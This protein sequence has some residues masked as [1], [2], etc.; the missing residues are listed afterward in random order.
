MDTLRFELSSASFTSAVTASSLHSHSRYFFSSVQLG[1]VGSSSPAITSVS[2][3]TVNEICTADELHY[4]PVPNSDWRVALWR[5]LPSPKAPKRN[6]P[7]LLLSGIG[8]NAV[9][10]DLSPECSFAR[11]M[12]GSGFDTWILELRGA[13]LSSLS[14]DTNLGKGNN[15]Q[16][17]VSNLLENFISV[18]ERLENVLDGGSKILGMQDR[19]SK[20]AGDFKQRFELIP[21][22]NWDF[23]NYLEEDVPSAM[24][25]VRTQTKSKDGKLLAVGHSMGGILL[26][27]LLSR[28]GFKGMDSG[29]AGV[30]TLASTFDYS[31]SGTLLKYLLPMKEPA[32]AINLPIMPIDTM[33]AMAH[34][35]MCRPPYSLSWL[36]ANISAPQMMDPEVIE[37]LVLNS[38]CTVP[39]KLLLQLTTAVDHGGLRDR[40]GTFCYKDHISKTNVPILALAGDW[41]I[42]CPPDAVYDTV[43]LIPEHLATYKVVG[44]PGG[45]HYGHQDL[46]SGR[47]ARNEVYPL[48]TRFLQQQDES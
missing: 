9:T 8:T 46:I 17:I 7:L 28:C 12:S 39:V 11:S 18:S 25:Y 21:H 5:Y 23:D 42:I 15:Q 29:L 3:T 13:G 14:V 30:T 20:R 19:L 45:P 33:L 32:Q 1:R 22:Y 37:K 43:K 48:I 24:D 36:T 41:D 10:Y 16:R 34:P 31:S 35:L 38:L 2:R 40:T 4:V 47:T 6:H 27:A 44:S 26:Y